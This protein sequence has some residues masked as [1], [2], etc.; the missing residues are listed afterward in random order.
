[1][2]F[3]QLPIPEAIDD[4]SAAAAEKRLSAMRNEP[5]TQNVLQAG[6]INLTPAIERACSKPTVQE[7]LSQLKSLVGKEVSPQALLPRFPP[8]RLFH[9][10]Y[11]IEDTGIYISVDD[12]KPNDAG[13]RHAEVGVYSEGPNLGSAGGPT[14]QRLGAIAIV[15]YEGLIAEGVVLPPQ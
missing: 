2:G 10:A 4:T 8:D 11:P 3:E 5:G 1:M 7:Y 9:R 15:P 14:L 13:N 12:S 6:G